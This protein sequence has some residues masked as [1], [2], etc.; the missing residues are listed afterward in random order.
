DYM[1]YAL[2]PVTQ[3]NTAYSRILKKIPEKFKDVNKVYILSVSIQAFPRVPKYNETLAKI[4]NELHP[5]VKEIDYIGLS[6]LELL[7]Y[8]INNHDFSLFKFI[9]TKKVLYDYIPYPNY[10]YKKYGEIKRTDYLNDIL[11][12]C[13]DEIRSTLF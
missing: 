5:H 1:K 10:Y 7:A 11:K 13:F 3:A 8:I 4:A 12:E 2:E 6:D 9:K